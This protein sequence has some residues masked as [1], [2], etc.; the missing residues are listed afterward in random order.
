M[1]WR[2]RKILGDVW[3][4]I[5]LLLITALVVHTIQDI[6]GNQVFVAFLGLVFLWLCLVWGI[7]IATGT[8][9]RAVQRSLL[10]FMDK[11][12]LRPPRAAA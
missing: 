8:G 6:R 9:D 7:I 11:S 4:L 2:I 10:K 5:T 12:D 3:I 1:I